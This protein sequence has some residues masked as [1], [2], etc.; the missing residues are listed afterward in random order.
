MIGIRGVVRF[1]VLMIVLGCVFWLLLWLLDYVG[2]PQPFD[3]IA[4][5]GLVVLAVL[6]L[7][8]LIL[9]VAGYPIFKRDDP[10]V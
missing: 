6:A 3:K 10:P 9:D 2:L 4:H 7:I 5:V 8:G 1:V